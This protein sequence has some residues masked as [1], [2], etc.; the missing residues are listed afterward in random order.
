[1]EFV[2]EIYQIVVVDLVADDNHRLSRAAQH[3]GHHHVQ[4]GDSG[5]DL[6]HEEY[7]VGFVYGQHHL[8]AYILFEE[9][10]AVDGIST[11]VYYRELLSVPVGF[12]VVAV[13]RGSGRGI[14]NGLTLSDQTV[15][16]SR[17]AH[18]GAAYD[19]Y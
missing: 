12:A 13:A 16:E 11:R 14:H 3:I 1:M 19:C 7:K 8:T 6:D 9:V 2:R 10:V 15:E 4:I 5:T 18:V 17:F